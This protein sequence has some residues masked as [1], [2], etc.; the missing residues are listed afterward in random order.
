MQDEDPGHFVLQAW[1]LVGR[2]AQGASLVVLSSWAKLERRH[3][4]RAFT[5]FRFEVIEVSVFIIHLFSAFSLGLLN[6]LNRFKVNLATRVSGTRPHR[7]S[8]FPAS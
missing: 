1:A 3:F 6:D 5:L 2:V 4:L 7:T 8:S